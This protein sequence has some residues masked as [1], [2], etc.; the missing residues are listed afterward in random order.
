MNRCRPLAALTTVI[1]LAALTG[2][3]L[4]GRTTAA[5][6]GSP[7]TAP[8]TTSATTPPPSA[9]SGLG[10]SVKNSGDIPDPCGLLT[11]Q[12]VTGLTGRDVTQIDEDGLRPGEENRYCQWQQSGGQLAVFLGRTTE[13]DFKIKIADATPVDDVGQDAFQLAGHLY[14]LYG[15][16]SIDVYSRGDSDAENLA[17]ATAVAK[18]VIP[19]I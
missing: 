3:G 15:T 10:D 16:V 18:A 2:C 14:V 11:K 8:T 4:V 17:E 7:A 12:Q 9:A 5:D 1:A 6:P 19:L 13:G